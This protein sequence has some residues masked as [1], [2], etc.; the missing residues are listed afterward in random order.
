MSLI[1]PAISLSGWNHCEN[2]QRSQCH[3]IRSQTHQAHE[4]VAI[5]LLFSTPA[6][7]VDVIAVRIAELL[8]YTRTEIHAEVS[9]CIVYS[10]QV[11]V[12]ESFAILSFGMIMCC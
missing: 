10:L 1:H 9:R 5:V 11:V 8:A 7:V 12:C 3:R 2:A 4:C 6:I